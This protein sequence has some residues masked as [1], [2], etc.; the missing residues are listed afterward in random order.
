MV[1]YFPTIIC[2]SYFSLSCKIFENQ[3]TM[4][5]QHTDNVLTLT[6]TLY[7]QFGTLDTSH[8]V[9]PRTDWSSY[10]YTYIGPAMTELQ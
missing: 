4:F 9:Q 5:L 10:M 6:Y 2:L 8:A 3:L 7:K 1:I